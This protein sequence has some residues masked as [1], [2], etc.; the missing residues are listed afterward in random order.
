MDRLEEFIRAN[1]EDFDEAVPGLKVWAHLDKQLDQRRGRALT[2]RTYM[3]A[4]AAV[5]L[6]LTAGGIGGLYVANTFQQKQVVAAVANAS[7]ELSEA[8]QYYDRLFE[9]K[10]QQLASYPH[11][12]SIDADLAQ[13]DQAMAELKRD[14]ANVP[15]GSEEQIIRNLINTYQLKLQ[16]L[17]RILDQL[18]SVHPTQE[19]TNEH[20]IGI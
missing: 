16:I 18:E 8:T 1:R 5:L 2:L 11:D 20:E 6:L 7:P 19:K 10:Y 15:K 13:I 17:E 4:A 3:R 9:Q 12:K 14:L